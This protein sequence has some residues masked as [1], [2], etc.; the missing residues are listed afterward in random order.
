M[1]IQV[2]DTLGV[3]LDEVMRPASTWGTYLPTAQLL[4]AQIPLPE[5]VQ[6]IAYSPIIGNLSTAGSVFQVSL[7]S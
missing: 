5:Y 4:T 3:R 2:A 7:T 6:K 1:L